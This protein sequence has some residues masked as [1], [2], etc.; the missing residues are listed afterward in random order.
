[1]RYLWRVGDREGEVHESFVTTTRDKAVPLK[2][3][4]KMM[5]RRG[6]T[7]AIVSDRLGS[8]G[9]CGATIIPTLRLTILILIVA[10][11]SSRLS[12]GRRIT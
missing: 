8:Y 5:K 3:F 4:T 1:M 6:R 9:E 10:R 11:L 2:F 7:C 12:R